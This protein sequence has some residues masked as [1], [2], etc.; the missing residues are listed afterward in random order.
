[1]LLDDYETEILI[2]AGDDRDGAG[3]AGQVATYV[4]DGA[5]EHVI[6]ANRQTI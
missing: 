5:I 2:D 4:A 3:I 1:M 6:A